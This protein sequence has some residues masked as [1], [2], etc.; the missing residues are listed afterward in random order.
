MPIIKPCK[1]GKELISLIR[2]LNLSKLTHN[3]FIINEL[4][5]N[6]FIF[7]AETSSYGYYKQ[8]LKHPKYTNYIIKVFRTKEAHKYDSYYVPKEIYQDYL[9]PIYKT[10][11]LLIQNKVKLLGQYE[12]WRTIL[13]KH[14]KDIHYLY[15]V[16]SNNVGWFKSQPVIF[17]F[18][19]KWPR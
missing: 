12:A 18:C 6:G 4:V 5:K 17:D 10:K 8:I 9:H 13:K 1:K 16:H 11:Q 19:S 14:K 2:K 3:D 15:D 7:L